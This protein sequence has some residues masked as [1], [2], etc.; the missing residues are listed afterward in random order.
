M[1]PG[2]HQSMRLPPGRGVLVALGAGGAALAIGGTGLLAAVVC[3][4]AGARAAVS[5]R[6]AFLCISQGVITTVCF[7]KINAHNYY[8][9]PYLFV[10]LLTNH[11]NN[12]HL[13]I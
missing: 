12:F 11:F 10:L 5:A 4:V 8:Y 7:P 1:A 13:I 6:Y 2:A 9:L 3:R